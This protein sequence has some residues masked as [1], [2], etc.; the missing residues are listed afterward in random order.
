MSY[1]RWGKRGQ[2]KKDEQ[3]K[4]G[5]KR[6]SAVMFSVPS[7]HKLN[8]N[9]VNNILCNHMKFIRNVCFFTVDVLEKKMK[10]YCYQFFHTYLWNIILMG[11]WMN[12]F[13]ICVIPWIC[14]LEWMSPFWD[15]FKWRSARRSYSEGINFSKL[16]NLIIGGWEL[17]SV[18]CCG[19]TSILRWVY[20]QQK[21]SS[22]KLK[23]ISNHLREGSL[24]T[25]CSSWNWIIH[26]LSLPKFHILP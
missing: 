8:V 25:F 21:L 5:D 20:L 10:P 18:Q 24:L 23:I 3:R 15:Y 12:C 1:R 11:Y 17:P 2:T 9:E 22:I 6:W 19:T 7:A 4:T 26:L 13:C 14:S 16:S